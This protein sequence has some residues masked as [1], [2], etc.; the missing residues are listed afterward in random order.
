MTLTGESVRLE[1]MTIEHL[2]PLCTVGLDPELWTW[3]LN[4]LETREHM[5]EYVEEALALRDVGSAI[6]FVTVESG[7]G[8]VIGST[9]FGNIDRRNRRYEIGWTWIAPAWQRT[10]INTEAKYLML[11]HAFEELDAVR[12]EFKTDALNARSRAAIAR[13]GAREEGILRNHMITADGRLRDS[14]YFSII[15]SE[16]PEVK[17]GLREKMGVRS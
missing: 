12:V 2:D 1:P 5:R 4:R 15:A 16:W 11:R 10:A 13:I 6:P 9:R 7:S 14:V 8:E 17:A 3:G